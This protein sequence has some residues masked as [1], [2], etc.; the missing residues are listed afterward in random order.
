MN[1]DNVDNLLSKKP[2]TSW[3]FL[4]PTYFSTSYQHSQPIFSTNPPFI[5][6]NTLF[7]DFRV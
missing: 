4:L 2:E 5:N 6:K 7:R 1:V 3:I